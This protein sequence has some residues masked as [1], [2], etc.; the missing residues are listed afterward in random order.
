MR[1]IFANP[2]MEDILLVDANN[3][4]NIVNCNVALLNI[5]SI[6]PSLSKI[7]INTYRNS[8]N[9]YVDGETL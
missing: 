3:A 2:D 6:F 8:A 1:E 5:K 9:V 7:L 4:F